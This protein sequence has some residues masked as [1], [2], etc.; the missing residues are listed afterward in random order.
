ME[1]R[2]KTIILGVT[3]CIAAY[4]SAE[5]T[6]GLKKLGADVWVIMTK[7]A[8]EFV[9]PLTFRTLSGNP[10]ISDMYDKTAIT[11]PVPHISVSDAADMILV[12]P[13]TANLIGK[14][15]NGIAD[16][17]LSTTIM[18]CKVPVIFAPAMN[19]K[20]WDNPIVKENIK[21][22]KKLGY[23]FIDPEFGEL[24]CGDI[25]EGRLACLDSILRSV[26]EKIGIKQDLSG[27]KVLITAGGTREPIDP[28][29]FIGN[30]S[31][32]KMG[33]ALARAAIDRGADVKII[34]ANVSLDFPKE[35]DVEVANTA[36]K[37]KEAVLKN[38]KSADIV[39]MTAAV[40]DFRP[41]REAE[42]KI[43]EGVPLA[44]NLKR[45]R[46]FCRSLG[47]T[48]ATRSWLAFRWNHGI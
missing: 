31:S 48:K 21:K 22:L 27:K 45:Q 2:N 28:V 25:G 13:A 34:S 26:T 30:R 44:L 35:A 32:G 43:K 12:A 42:S 14:V 38:Y 1:L 3:G 24:A 15:A 17:M 41:A 40:A 8:Q 23:G 10:C 11:A 18:A 47:S 39:I 36:S 5:I 9:A 7:S 46:I 37:M 16:D 29:R 6:R 4:K 19:T 33:Y 20:M